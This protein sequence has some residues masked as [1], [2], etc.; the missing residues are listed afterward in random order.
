[1]TDRCSNGKY[2]YFEYTRLPSGR[3]RAANL[4]LWQQHK[5]ACEQ[6]QRYEAEQYQRAANAPVYDWDLEDAK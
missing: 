5:A 1:M 4:I 6:C 3:K 2:L